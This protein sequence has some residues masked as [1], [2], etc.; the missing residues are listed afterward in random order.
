M[1]TPTELSTSHTVS[2]KDTTRAS[3]TKLKRAESTQKSAKALKSPPSASVTIQ[4]NPASKS[5]YVTSCSSMNNSQPSTSTTKQVTASDKT[6]PQPPTPTT[7][8]VTATILSSKNNPQP[9]TA[10]QVTTT[11]FSNKTDHHPS[12]ATAKPVNATMLSN[13]TNPQLST[14]TTMLS[15]KT[16]PQLS[17]STTTPVLLTSDTKSPTGTSTSPIPIYSSPAKNRS[18]HLDPA[19]RSLCQ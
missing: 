16:N 17:T 15:N 13:K 19:S 7:K 9:S 1:V 10:K 6:G 18:Q 2:S 12:T 8:L 4:K 11:T 5:V 3:K 14:S